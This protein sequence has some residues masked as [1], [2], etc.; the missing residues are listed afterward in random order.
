MDKIR[1]SQFMPFDS[2]KGFREALREKEKQVVSKVELSS[3]LEEDINEKLLNL[4]VG[5][6]ITVC[7]YDKD[8]YYTITG[9]VSKVDYENKYL[10]IV[11][12]KIK[13][14]SLRS[15]FTM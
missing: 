7:F 15:L 6:M 4:K 2:L 1:V 13:F 12:K 3:D 8:N 10:A 14:E 5:M 11:K 9:M